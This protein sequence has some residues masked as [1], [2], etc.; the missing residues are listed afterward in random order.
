MPALG[1]FSLQWALVLTLAGL[2][3]AAVAV[4]T[5]ERR[6]AATL[7]R[8]ATLLA[9]AFVALAA[10]VL[11]TA[12]LRDDFR[13]A[14]VANF[15]ARE[16][17]LVYKVAAFWAGGPGSLLFWALVLGGLAAA[18][19][20]RAPAGPAPTDAPVVARAAASTL[21]VL[22][23][24]LAFFLAL[25][26]TVTPP[27]ATLTLP[28]TDGQGLN[29]LLQNP[30]MAIHP[31][32]LFLG[33]AGLAVPFA[34]TLGALAA[35]R[36]DEAWRRAC[37]H[38]TLLAWAA[39]TAG[40][41]L[42][43]LWAYLELGWGGYWAWDPVENA[44]LLPWL[45]TTGLLHLLLLQEGRARLRVLAVVLVLVSFALTLFATYLTRSGV[46]DSLHAFAPDAVLGGL[47]LAA[48]VAGPVAGGALMV[49]RWRALADDADAE[50]SR[51]DGWLLLGALAFAL[52]TATVLLGT[53]M[54]V[55]SRALIG[56]QARVGTPFF[57]ETTAPL[58]FLAL[59]CMG[60]AG[61]GA[62]RRAW[63][64]PLGAGV[65]AKIIE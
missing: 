57:N 52:L 36:L 33:Y 12:F 61:A 65:V 13:F 44:S 43:A 30:W 38:W 55:L 25:L 21:G 20:V 17:P 10:G 26:A 58:F 15:S 64:W 27:F 42:G 22:L 3:A 34:L 19:A 31:P 62:M 9:A 39:L 47:L 29:P 11:W 5:P 54:P 51:R 41:V 16:L 48:A 6:V 18:F 8:R 56:Q 63:A 45:T 24:V 60:L 46:L 49:A 37:R 40:I 53:M 32:V 59:A 14:Y 35:G 50:L 7:A 1:Q 2:A 4:A 28:P 23:T